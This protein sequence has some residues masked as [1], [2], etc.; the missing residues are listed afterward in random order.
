MNARGDAVWLVDPG[1]EIPP[2][3][4]AIHGISTAT[5]RAQGLVA[6]TASWEVALALE[7]HWAAG[8]VVIVYNAA[9]DLRVLTE[10]LRRHSLPDLTLGPILDPLVL[11]RQAERYRKGKKRLSDAVDRFGVRVDAQ[12]EAEADA[13]AAISVARCLAPMTGFGDW[14]PQ[15][16][17]SIQ[18]DWNREW[19]TSFA[20]WLRRQGGDWRSV[21]TSWPLAARGRSSC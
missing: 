4:A 21:D 1:I 9:Y 7:A 5:A 8:A 10:E 13:R 19:A 20:D 15:Q 14:S 18:S 16:A 11:W 17:E 6:R 2:G 3:A 12:H